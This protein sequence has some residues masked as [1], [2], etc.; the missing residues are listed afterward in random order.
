[1]IQLINLYLDKFFGIEL[2]RTR[3]KEAI[4]FA[5]N[6]FKGK[7]IIAVEIGI[8][9]GENSR[10][11]NKNLNIEKFYLIDPYEKY[12]DYDHDSCSRELEKAK[13]QA[14]KINNFRNNIWIEKYS[15]NAIK[16]ILEKI[17]FLYIDGN[18]DYDYVKKDL[19]LYWGKI[20]DK[21]I[22]SG[23]DI[24]CEGVSKAVLEFAKEKNLQVYFGERRDWWI[25][26]V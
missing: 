16:D 15:E 4:K 18:H 26:K 3:P 5:K 8:F 22:I 24:Q 1:M 9:K 21:G 6:Y 19:K 7:K 12:T 17:D 25:L 2:I 10:E 20:N 13:K 14:H 23:H 11:I